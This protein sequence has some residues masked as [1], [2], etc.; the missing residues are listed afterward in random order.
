MNF[1]P[2]GLFGY[3]SSKCITSL[4]VPSSKGVS[5]GPI[6]TAFLCNHEGVVHE[7]DMGGDIP[8]HDIIGDGRSG[9]ACGGVG[10]HALQH[11]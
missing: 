1:T 11:V 10:L 4:N 2:G 7:G 3:A 6:M 9:D 5:A 8:G